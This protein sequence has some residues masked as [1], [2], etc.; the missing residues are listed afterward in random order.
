MV[1]FPL[2]EV[3][4]SRSYDW[5][6]G[7]P[8]LIVGPRIKHGKCSWLSTLLRILKILN[9]YSWPLKI[10]EITFWLLCPV[11][12]YYPFSIPFTYKPFLYSHAPISYQNPNSTPF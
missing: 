1:A 3:A 7:D 10:L 9:F 11:I 4:I 2:S 5:L 8:Y 12:L 6:G